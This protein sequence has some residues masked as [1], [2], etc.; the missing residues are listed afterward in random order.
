M[1]FILTHSEDAVN[2]TST[3]KAQAC[4]WVEGIIM[5]RYLDKQKQSKINLHSHRKQNT[6]KTTTSNFSA[7]SH[8]CLLK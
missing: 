5:V 4:A 1:E 8:V 2:E 7:I 6:T 3:Y